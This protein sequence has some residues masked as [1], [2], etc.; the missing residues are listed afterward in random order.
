MLDTFTPTQA[1]RAERESAVDSSLGRV[2]S[3]NGRALE[4]RVIWVAV[5]ST[6]HIRWVKSLAAF[7]RRR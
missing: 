5:V 2:E 1:D 7:G 6:L 3:S 4:L